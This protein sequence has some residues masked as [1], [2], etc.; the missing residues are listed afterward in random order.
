[1]GRPRN[2]IIDPTLKDWLETNFPNKSTKKTY[3]SALRLFKQNLNIKNLGKYLKEGPDADN[4]IKRYLSSLNERPS[5][6]VSSYTA[7]VKA[8]FLDHDIELKKNTWK[9]LRRRG[10]LPK[11]ITAQTR[12]KKPS[13]GQL[14]RIINYS[15][16]RG[17]ALFLFLA[18]S[19]CRVGETLKLKIADLDLEADP[20]QAFIRGE[21]TKSG[22]GERTVFFSYEA[23][24]AIKDWLAIKDK[25]GK[26]DG[27][28]TYESP[29]IFPFSH[30]TASM[31]LY[32]ALDKAGLAQRDHRT[33][34]RVYHIHSLR[35]FFRTQIG[36]DLDT[37]N[38]LMG[39]SQYLDS[40]Y[41]R[42]EHNDIAN[43]YLENMG[44]VSIYAVESPDLVQ[45][46]E[47]LKDRILR[48]ESKLAQIEKL[49]I[50]LVNGKD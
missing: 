27:K 30:P 34:R 17:R 9:K 5:K 38:A 21:T 36:L 37:T 24:D 48:T 2:P 6:T 8:F 31:M 23:K 18:S 1:M 35:K 26:R 11:R 7:A 40:A 22:V 19:G 50:G 32:G 13:K 47:E 39:H 41:L 46:N 29:L 20:P 14:K 45:E 3:L 25:T 42:Q 43:A 28:G 49:L 15:S 33:G 4:D 12:D 10:F 44:N 16:I